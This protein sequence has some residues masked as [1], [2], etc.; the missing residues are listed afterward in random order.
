M[1]KSNTV[2]ISKEQIELIARALAE[3]RR[4]MMLKQI[5]AFAGPMPCSELIRLHDVGA[6]TMSRHLR[7]LQLAGLIK[8]TRDG[9][10]MD[11]EL[12]REMLRAYLNWVAEF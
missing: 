10:C 6:P 8:A 3:P 4:M 2:T 5:G 9:K 7:E 11:Y 1:A 12:D